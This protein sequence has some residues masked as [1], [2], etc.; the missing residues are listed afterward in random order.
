MISMRLPGGDPRG[1][2]TGRP[3][4]SIFKYTIITQ[5]G[6]TNRTP[7]L[8]GRNSDA[9]G[10]LLGD[11]CMTYRQLQ[12]GVCSILLSKATPLLHF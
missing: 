12:V 1:P 7:K 5:S 6:P 3:K 4:N 10:Y 9:L 11:R 2:S 8:R